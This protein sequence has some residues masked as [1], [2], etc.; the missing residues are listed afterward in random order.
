MAPK[1]LF[2]VV[3]RSLG[4]WFTLSYGLELFQLIAMESQRFKAPEHVVAST[5]VGIGVGIFLFMCPGLVTAVAYRTKTLRDLAK[6][7][8]SPD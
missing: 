5:L 1:E 6:E 8:H 2:G 7:Q 4:L 3:V